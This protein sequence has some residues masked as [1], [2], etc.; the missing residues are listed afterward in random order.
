[1]SYQRLK[2][3][4][5]D[6]EPDSLALLNWQ[7]EKECPELKVVALCQGA[8][9]AMQQIEK[10]APDVVFLDIEMPGM[11]GLQLLQRLPEI[12]FAPI[13]ITAYSQYAIK[14]I[15]LGAFDYLLKPVQRAELKTTVER[16]LQKRLHS[17]S[18][19]M[20]TSLQILLDQLHDVRKAPKITIH[21]AEQTYF[22]DISEVL[23]LQS[24]NNYTHFFLKNGRPLLVA[25]TLKYFEGLLEEHGFFRVH[26]SFLIN[27]NAVSS[28]RK[29]EGGGI[30]LSNG[31]QIPIARSKREQLFGRL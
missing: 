16:L 15:K 24:D 28:I 11:N 25:R 23:Y 13:F 5:I 19:E 12:H 20:K 2:T 4:L 22:V 27:L 9:E 18:V 26:A 17:S 7:I 3:I 8:Q 10:R 31:V 14:A 6:D 30:I 1:M 29:G 21:T